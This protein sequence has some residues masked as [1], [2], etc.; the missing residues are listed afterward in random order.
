MYIFCYNLNMQKIKVEAIV[1]G[2][3]E[4]VWEFWNE[5]AHITKWAFATNDWECPYAENDLK[6]GGKFLTRMSAKDGSASFDFTGVYTNIIP[7]EKIEYTAD[8]GRKVSVDFQKVADGAVK[9]V[10]E[11]EPENI[12]SEDMQR[13][14]WQAILNN[15]K[16]HVESN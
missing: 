4:K 16:L 6:M 13:D 5:P 3:I 11:F 14:G 8:D 2:N 7:H 9:I 12:N 10:E 15:F 1:R